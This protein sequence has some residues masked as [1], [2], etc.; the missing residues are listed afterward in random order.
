MDRGLIRFD[1]K[2]DLPG[3]P[4]LYSTTRK[5]LEI[6][7]LKDLRELPSLSDIDQLIP[8]G[9]G[10]D[11][12]EKEDKLGDMQAMGLQYQADPGREEEWE[13]ITSDIAEIKTS[14]DF[15]EKEKERERERRDLHRSEDIRERLT[16]G[17]VVE[18][19]DLRW[20]SRYEA[21]HVPAPT[22]PP[23]VAVAS[24]EGI[25][26]GLALDSEIVPLESVVDDATVTSV[27]GEDPNRLGEILEGL[28]NKNAEKIDGSPSDREHLN[29][30]VYRPDQLAQALK[31]FETDE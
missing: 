20:L 7:G 23:E 6:F 9:I 14:T 30:S 4:M 31:D 21:K 13:K 11:L 2:S 27:T 17:E 25:P 1:G 12:E 16:V 8:E 28:K 26:E 5:F 19:K 29:K 15:F 18:D 22:A 3:K 24:T 10:D